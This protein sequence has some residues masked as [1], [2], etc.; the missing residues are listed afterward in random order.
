MVS[1]MLLRRSNKRGHRISYI[2]TVSTAAATCVHRRATDTHQRPHH[3]RLPAT[4][5]TGGQPGPAATKPLLIATGPARRSCGAVK[6]VTQLISHDTYSAVGAC[7]GASRLDLSCL[8]VDWTAQ[9]ECHTPC[10]APHQGHTSAAVFV[11]PG[12]RGGAAACCH[13]CQRHCQAAVPAAAWA[14]RYFPA[15]IR[16]S[17]AACHHLEAPPSA[18]W[19]CPSGIQTASGA[20]QDTT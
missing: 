18:P 15:S 16:C 19:P 5:L 3:A 14:G 1:S 4:A 17:T 6:G 12:D 13:G 20:A 8:P 11:T 7:P 9:P 10:L 2:Y